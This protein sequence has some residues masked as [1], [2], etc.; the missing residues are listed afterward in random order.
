M[1][2]SRPVGVVAATAAAL[3]L[4]VLVSV[5]E[6]NT[7]CFADYAISRLYKTKYDVCSKNNTAICKYISLSFR[8]IN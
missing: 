6:G 2:S 4:A 8:C 7:S 3:L 5:V 1:A